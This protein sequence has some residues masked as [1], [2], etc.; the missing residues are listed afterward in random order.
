MGLQR[1]TRLGETLGVLAALVFS[2]V[3]VVTRVRS[4]EAA[5]GGSSMT[6]QTVVCNRLIPG[7]ADER[8]CPFSQQ[9][10]SLRLIVGPLEEKSRRRLQARG[11]HEAMPS[12]HNLYVAAAPCYASLRSIT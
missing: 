1:T 9:Y 11:R 7:E 8:R 5:L 6:F 3:V 10:I 12:K 4:G 2:L